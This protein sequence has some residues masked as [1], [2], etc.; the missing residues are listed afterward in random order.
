MVTAMDL[1]Q[2][3]EISRRLHPVMLHP[4][5]GVVVAALLA[6]LIEQRMARRRTPDFSVAFR[7]IKG[8]PPKAPGPR[9]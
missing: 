6:A 4:I 5:A 2:L 1:S 7:D 3:S 8:P 9:P